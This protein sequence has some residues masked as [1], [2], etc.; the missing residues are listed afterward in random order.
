VEH[1]TAY[2]VWYALASD[3][4][5]PAPDPNR[6]KQYVEATSALNLVITDLENETFYYVW[7]KAKNPGGTSDFSEPVKESPKAPLAPPP[8]PEIQDPQPEGTF[9][10]V[11]WTAI[12]Q[13]D[14]YEVYYIGGNALPGTPPV[15]V[16][17][18][19]IDSVLTPELAD[20]TTYYVWVRARNTAGISTD[21]GV[22]SCTTN[23][24]EKVIRTFS[25]G[26]A[27][28]IIDEAAKTI[29]VLVP[30]TTNLAQITPVITLS[31]GATVSPASESVVDFSGGPVNFTVTAQNGTTKVYTVTVTK[32][33][34][35][36]LTLAWDA[37]QGFTD[38]GIGAFT[39]EDVVLVKGGTD[40]TADIDL[41]GSF[42]AYEWYVDNGLKGRGTPDADTPE[43]HL[44]AQAYLVGF[45][46]LDL[47]VYDAAG[48]PYA[49]GLRFEVK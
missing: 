5:S 36:S 8:S 45:H 1:A 48:I 22:K 26:T 14:G 49:K 37:D 41:K 10:R 39:V 47:I 9:I 40:S 20:D 11:K 28:G 23:K 44:D 25:I 24:G 31:S 35:A 21:S 18:G 7:I 3:S 34:Q 42:T 33:G 15:Q 2:E 32:K 12:P 30:F 38:S 46:Q 13:A 29:H 27:Q 17:G 4:E 6:A 43:V 16:E 19:G